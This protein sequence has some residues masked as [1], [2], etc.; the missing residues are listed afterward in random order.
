MARHGAAGGLELTDAFHQRGVRLKLAVEL[1]FGRKLVGHLRGL[2]HL[3]HVVM[4]GAALGGEGKHGHARVD[5]HQ[6]LAG[7]GA[8]NGDGR[9]LLGRGIGDHGAVAEDHHAFIAPLV[10]GQL[11]DE[12]AGHHLDAGG[13]LD[14]CSAGRRTFPVELMAPATMPS[15]SPALS[16]T[17]P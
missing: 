8:G 7:G 9:Q 13:R 6:L 12:A 11:H 17:A 16:I 15:A 2:L 3:G 5:V 4:L 14:V 1:Q 10:V